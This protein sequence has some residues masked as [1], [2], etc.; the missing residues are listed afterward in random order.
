ML[1]QFNQ[2]SDVCLGDVPFDRQIL[3]AEQRSTLFF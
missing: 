1:K 2:L 3:P